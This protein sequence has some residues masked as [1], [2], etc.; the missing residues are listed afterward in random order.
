MYYSRHRYLSAPVMCVRMCANQNQPATCH[1]ATF[2]A[3]Q[4]LISDFRS[5][6]SDFRCPMG[7]TTAH[8]RAKPWPLR[9]AHLAQLGKHKAPHCTWAIAK[10]CVLCYVRAR[11]AC[12][13]RAAAPRVCTGLQAM[14][15]GPTLQALAASQGNQPKGTH[16]GHT[17]S[18]QGHYAR[19]ARPQ[20]SR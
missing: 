5:S 9:L 15:A 18:T 20:A 3:P 19:Q 14:Q 7:L 12:T 11:C 2:C 6:I 16:H 10:R 8:A 4:R 1:P 17:P 13:T